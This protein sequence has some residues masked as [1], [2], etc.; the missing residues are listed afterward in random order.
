MSLPV[1]V[2]VL[3]HSEAKLGAR[4]VLIALAEFAHDDGTKAFPSVETLSERARM[5]RR[6]VQAALRSLEADGSIEQTGT[7]RS[8]TN[9]Y[10]VVMGGAESA[11]RGEVASDRGEAASP[12]PLG[13]VIDP[14]GAA[15]Q[16]LVAHYVDTA[17][18]T[19]VDPPKRVVGQVASEIGNLLREGQPPER[20]QRALQLLVERRLNPSTLPS[21]ILE[22]GAGPARRK[23]IEE[24]RQGANLSGA[25]DA[26]G[27]PATPSPTPPPPTEEERREM[28]ERLKELQAGIG[29]PVD[30]AKLTTEHPETE[31][32]ESARA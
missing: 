16:E 22:A 31:E 4:L 8:G 29:R 2:W 9:V 26:E 30:E 1:M 17:R 14:P 32:D 10:R 5:S 7:T 24:E 6:G 13:P 20:I 25:V 15:G 12:D 23:R 18:D 28:V 11:P 21:L 19:G 27:N 3:Q